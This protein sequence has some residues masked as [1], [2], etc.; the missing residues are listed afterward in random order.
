MRGF[1]IT[2]PTTLP[3]L[4]EYT[5]YESKWFRGDSEE[6]YQF[7]IETGEEVPYGPD[8]IRYRFNHHGFRAPP[9]V[10]AK[11]KITE[12]YYGCSVMQG[13]GLPVEHTIP[14]LAHDERHVPFNM[15]IAGASNDLIARTV[16]STVP[17]FKP[18]F[19]FIYWTYHTRR[20][21]YDEEGN[22][23]QWL[24]NWKDQ[25]VK[26][27]DKYVPHMDAQGQLSHFTSNVNNLLK[28]ITMVDL[29]L[30]SNSTDYA[31]ALVDAHCLTYDEVYREFFPF[32]DNYLR[33]SLADIQVDVSRDLQHPGPETSKKIANGIKSIR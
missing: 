28:N 32:S 2:S 15:G 27:S 19:V 23:I 13:Y 12:A 24:R 25:T 33:A 31:W 30:K 10:V 7:N 17:L 1:K 4:S 20:E 5:N 3:D 22:P 16:M 11:H 6:K 14:Y 29:F 18:T 21:I 8:D 9:F 26:V